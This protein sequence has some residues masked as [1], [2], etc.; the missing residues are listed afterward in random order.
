MNS[1]VIFIEIDTLKFMFSKKATKIWQNSHCKVHYVP[2]RPQK[3]EKWYQN[4]YILGDF[5]WYSE[6]FK[7]FKTSYLFD[8]LNVVSGA[9]LR[10]N[11]D[12]VIQNQERQLNAAKRSILRM[13]GNIL[14]H[15]FLSHVWY[16]CKTFQPWTFQPQAS[17]LHFSTLDFLTMNFFS[18]KSS[19]W[20]LFSNVFFNQRVQKF[21]FEKSRV[22]NSGMEMSNNLLWRGHFNL[23]FFTMNFLTRWL[24][25]SWLLSLGLKHP[26]ILLVSALQ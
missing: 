14:K 11:T 3:F 12:D 4:L 7:H 2:R 18:M 13:L 17:F 8:N 15:I 9:N 16:G 1:Q 5:I 20:K 24:K 19:Y 22:E 25:S 6:T 23:R 10:L 26:P 21:M